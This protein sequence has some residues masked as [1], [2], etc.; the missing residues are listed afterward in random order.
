MIN[1]ITF[2]T[3]WAVVSREKFFSMIFMVCNSIY[4][5]LDFV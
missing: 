1:E 3:I 4:R 2:S 5:I